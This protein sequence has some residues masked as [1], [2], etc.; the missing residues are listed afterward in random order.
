MDENENTTPN[1]TCGMIECVCAQVAPHVEGCRY[2]RSMLCPVAIACEHGY[3]VCPECDPCTCP[4]K[5]T[6]PIRLRQTVHNHPPRVNLLGA[7]DPYS[8][9]DSDPDETKRPP[10]AGRDGRR[11]RE[12]AASAALIARTNMRITIWD[13]SEICRRRE[14]TLG[15]HESGF[16]GCDPLVLPTPVV[17]VGG[18]FGRRAG[19]LTPSAHDCTYCTPPVTGKLPQFLPQFLLLSQASWLRSEVP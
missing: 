6:M 16:P 8:D 7:T 13:D 4:P 2:R 5:G 3:D 15:M 12:C 14:S 10:Y 19:S 18:G 1:C 11:Q 17:P 9:R